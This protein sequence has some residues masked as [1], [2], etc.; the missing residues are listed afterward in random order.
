MMKIL[1]YCI[2]WKPSVAQGSQIK[3][4]AIF[5]VKS[6]HTQLL[7]YHNHAKNIPVGLPSSP[8]QILGKLVHGFLSFDRTNKQQRLQLSQ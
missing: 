1:Y 3:I 8:I 4:L 2:A 6:G 7:E 5:P